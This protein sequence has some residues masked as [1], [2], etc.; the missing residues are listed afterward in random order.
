MAKNPIKAV[1][2]KTSSSLIES[3]LPTEPSTARIMVFKLTVATIA[4]AAFAGAATVK[5]VACPDGK[6]FASNEAVSFEPFFV[7]TEA[8]EPFSLPSAVLSSLFAMTCKS[9]SSTVN[10]ARMF[11]N[12]SD[13]HST[14]LS[15]SPNPVLLK[16]LER[17][18]P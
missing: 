15:V 12:P 7:F 8:E 5:R 6:N 17:T 10:V 1:S 4:L 13:S 2:C 16:A 3:E 14:M 18:D 11:T 9:R